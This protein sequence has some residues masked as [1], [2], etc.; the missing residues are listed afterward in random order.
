MIPR[1]VYIPLRWMD[2]ERD[3]EMDEVKEGRGKVKSRHRW[4]ME[5]WMCKK[6]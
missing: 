5:R 4:K 1:A 6:G 2:R 3:G